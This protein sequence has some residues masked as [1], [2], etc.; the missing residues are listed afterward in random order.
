M[1]RPA[2]ALEPGVH[3]SPSSPAGIEYAFPLGST[4]GELSGTPPSSSVSSTYSAPLFGVGITPGVVRGR[5]PARPKQALS[6]A[7][8]RA[9]ALEAPVHAGSLGDLVLLFVGGVLLAGVLGGVL[10]SGVLGGSLGPMLRR[11]TVD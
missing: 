3:V 10:L 7:A 5:T 6:G 8:G 4:R 11:R 1:A 9:R 2:L